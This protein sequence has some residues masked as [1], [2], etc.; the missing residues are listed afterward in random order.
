MTG[1]LTTTETKNIV[2]TPGYGMKH[3]MVMYNTG[4]RN[5]V[6]TKTIG[7]SD[8]NGLPFSYF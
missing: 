4:E 5:R 2:L 7:Y 3:I 8:P 6:I 1:L